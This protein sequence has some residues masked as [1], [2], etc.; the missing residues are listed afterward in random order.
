MVGYGLLQMVGL[1]GPTIRGSFGP[2]ICCNFVSG[3]CV[4]SHLMHG[5][6]HIK[7]M[8]AIRYVFNS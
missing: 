3:I 6:S 4:L 7:V 5:V 1:L 2:A 8:R